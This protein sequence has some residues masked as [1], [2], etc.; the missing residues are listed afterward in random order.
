MMQGCR[1]ASAPHGNLCGSRVPSFQTPSVQQEPCDVQHFPRE[2][3]KMLRR[4]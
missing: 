2:L 3:S 1:L 4:K